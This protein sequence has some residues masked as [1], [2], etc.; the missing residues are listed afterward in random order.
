MLSVIILEKKRTVMTNFKHKKH[1]VVFQ[2]FLKNVRTYCDK[3]INGECYDIFIG[4]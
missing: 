1:V 2:P 4:Y 3:I